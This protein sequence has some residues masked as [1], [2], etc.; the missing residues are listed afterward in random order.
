MWLV[1]SAI[2]VLIKLCPKSHNTQVSEH[3]GSRGWTDESRQANEQSSICGWLCDTCWPSC[4]PVQS[5]VSVYRSNVAG[6]S[7]RPCVKCVFHNDCQNTVVGNGN[8]ACYWHMHNTWT[9]LLLILILPSHAN[10]S[11]TFVLCYPESKH[12]LSDISHGCNIFAFTLVSDVYFSVFRGPPCL[13]ST[14][15]CSHRVQHCAFHGHRW[16]V[17]YFDSQKHWMRTSVLRDVFFIPLRQ[18]GPL[19]NILRKAIFPV[20]L[21]TSTLWQLSFDLRF[22][23]LVSLESDLERADTCEFLFPSYT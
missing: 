7:T 12:Q 8:R 23:L 14:N 5:H 13:S 4:G 3:S 11:E 17:K 18:Q 15:L 22:P 19:L 9:H 16:T 2:K 6:R 1:L 20:Y 10:V 21:P